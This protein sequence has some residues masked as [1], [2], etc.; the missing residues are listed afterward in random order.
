VTL[1][2]EWQRFFEW[3]A[4]KWSKASGYANIQGTRPDTLAAGLSDS[5]A[6]LLAWIGEKLAEWSDGE[7]YEAFGADNLLTTASVF[8][9]TNSIG[10]SF[11]PYFEHETG[12]PHPLIEVPAAIAVQTHEGEYP[13]SLA[14]AS[15]LDVHSFRKL[16]HGGHFTAFEAPVEI[17]RDIIELERQVR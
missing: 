7:G 8:W 14:E 2:P 13:R 17:A 16:E 9:F 10:T 11:R 15:Y 3:L 1:D 5:P 6:G 4:A 12:P